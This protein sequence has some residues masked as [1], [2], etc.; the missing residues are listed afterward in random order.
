MEVHPLL[1][2]RRLYL[3]AGKAEGSTPLNAFDNA[4]LDAGIGDVNLI[5]VSSIVP[6][7]VE[8]VMDKPT[9][10]RG[11]ISAVRLRR[12]NE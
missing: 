1:E 11:G 3:V 2:V 10:P 5:K 4:L 8:V 6:P 12:A 9:L 7:G